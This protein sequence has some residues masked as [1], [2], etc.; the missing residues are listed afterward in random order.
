MS[1]PAQRERQLKTPID[2]NIDPHMDPEYESENADDL[3]AN[4]IGIQ[5]LFLSCK[6][7]RNIRNLT[8]TDAGNQSDWD[9]SII[10]KVREKTGTVETSQNVGNKGNLA[11]GNPLSRI[12]ISE[13]KSNSFRNRDNS[14]QLQRWVHESS[15]ERWDNGAINTDIS[16]A[17][18]NHQK[19]F[20]KKDDIWSDSLDINHQKDEKWQGKSGG[21]KMASLDGNISEQS[22][23]MDISQI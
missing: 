22:Y 21:S 6:L 1:S 23:R 12:S 10:Q 20:P 13:S 16:N 15:V 8:C 9:N 7:I 5:L 17:S 14:G 4:S 3:S 11:E 19:N 2:I 18:W